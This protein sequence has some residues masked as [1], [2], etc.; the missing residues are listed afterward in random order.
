MPNNLLNDEINQFNNDIIQL[1]QQACENIFTALQYLNNLF[2]DST[3]HSLN[4]EI[5]N[6]WLTSMLK[7]MLN[8]KTLEEMRAYQTS[9][10]E[11]ILH[12]PQ[13]PANKPVIEAC[14]KNIDILLAVRSTYLNKLSSHAS[15]AKN[16]GWMALGTLLI[17]VGVLVPPVEIVVISL[18]IVGYVYGAIDFAK[19]AAE[20]LS[21]KG[22]PKLGQRDTSQFSATVKN[23]IDPDR[24]TPSE[25]VSLL[26]SAKKKVIKTAGLIASGIGLTSGGAA[27][28]IALP[29]LAALFPPALPFV[30][31]AVGLAAAVVAGGMYIRK[32][33][34]EKQKVK[35]AINKQI[36]ISN[37]YKNKLSKIQSTNLELET[38]ALIEKE[39]LGIQQNDHLNNDQKSILAE[40]LAA[41]QTPEANQ[42]AENATLKN[43]NMTLEKIA[44]AEQQYLTNNDEDESGTEGEG[45][46]SNK[47]QIEQFAENIDKNEETKPGIGT[48]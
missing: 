19:E 45:G 6:T 13:T 41:L 27:L 1:E 7:G 46:K 39:L 34:Q 21:K 28:L 5:I 3:K 30:L 18:G 20:P 26:Q 17:I 8:A 12:V 15:I 43:L 48:R 47:N 38:T 32:L 25:S 22:L 37:Y 33:Y 35:Q 40:N 23:L 44:Y 29:S 42:S 24:K 9:F 14:L 11:A 4:I 31:A 16:F 36:E 10:T 2:E